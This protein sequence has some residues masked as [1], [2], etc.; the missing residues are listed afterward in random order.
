MHIKGNIGIKAQKY[1]Y[2]YNENTKVMHK[3]F[4]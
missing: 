4:F 2:M 3:L 1:K